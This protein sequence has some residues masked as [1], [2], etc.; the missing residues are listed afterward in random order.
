MVTVSAVNEERL[1]KKTVSG[2]LSALQHLWLLH[3]FFIF[4]S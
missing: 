3:P 4:G 1:K 2:N